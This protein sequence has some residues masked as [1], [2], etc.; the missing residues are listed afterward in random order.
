[1]VREKANS[2]DEEERP[3]FEF[4]INT[5]MELEILDNQKKLKIIYFPK[6]PQCFFLGQ[7]YKSVIFEDLDNQN[8]QTQLNSIFSKF[9]IY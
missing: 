4:F 1:M 8:V 6:L 5:I 9:K 7:H 3:I 2:G